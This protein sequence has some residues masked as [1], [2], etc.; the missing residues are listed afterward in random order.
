MLAMTKKSP[1]KPLARWPSTNLHNDRIQVSFLCIIIF[2]ITLTRQMSR[3]E[4]LREHDSENA[5]FRLQPKDLVLVDRIIKLHVLLLRHD[6]HTGVNLIFVLV[7]NIWLMATFHMMT[8]M[9]KMKMKMTSNWPS[10]WDVVMRTDGAYRT[11]RWML[12]DLRSKINIIISKF[13]I[14]SPAIVIIVIIF[15]LGIVLSP[16]GPICDV[17]CWTS[18]STVVVPFLKRG[19]VSIWKILDCH[20]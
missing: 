18:E 10:F 17:W 12:A 20:L 3:G 15:S 9:T 6:Y 1:S 7:F 13:I 2:Q 4:D 16:A 8:M 19:H 14:I 5:L 11:I